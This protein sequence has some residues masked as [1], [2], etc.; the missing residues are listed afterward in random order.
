[1]VKAAKKLMLHEG[2][3]YPLALLVASMKLSVGAQNQ[4]VM[5]ASKPAILKGS[6]W[7]GSARWQTVCP[8]SLYMAGKKKVSGP[9]LTPFSSSSPG[10]D[11]FV[12]P[13][14]RTSHRCR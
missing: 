11:T 14:E 7:P 5:G 13:G 10:P 6:G 12:L 4:P 8:R 9:V 1:M 2:Q 3:V